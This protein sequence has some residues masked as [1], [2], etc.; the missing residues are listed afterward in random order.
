[1]KLSEMR[2]PILDKK[3]TIIFCEN[4]DNLIETEYDVVV[5]I[6]TK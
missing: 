3:I 6:I 5:K 1:M 4:I 2:A